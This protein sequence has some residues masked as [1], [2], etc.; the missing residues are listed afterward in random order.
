MRDDFK[1]F[2]NPEEGKQ[3][4]RHEMEKFFEHVLTHD[5]QDF[6]FA[7]MIAGHNNEDGSTHVCSMGGGDPASICYA[8]LK[9]VDEIL[10]IDERVG[11]FIILGILERLHKLTE[12]QK[13][14]R[15]ELSAV[16]KADIAGPDSKQ[17]FDAV[18][19]LLN[20]LKKEQGGHNVH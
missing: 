10:E 7:L 4:V 11:M 14:R 8:I 1:S 20:T 17:A 6:K 3:N 19:E 2:E 9:S 12:K 16:E 13:R 5:P 18:T 15:N